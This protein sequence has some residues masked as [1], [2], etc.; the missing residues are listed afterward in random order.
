MNNNE[1]SDFNLENSVIVY[2]VYLEGFMNADAKLEDYSE[3]IDSG[4]TDFDEA[5]KCAD[6][7]F[8]NCDLPVKLK[9]ARITI[10][11]VLIHESGEREV[12]DCCYEKKFDKIPKA[13]IHL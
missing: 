4:Y 6:Y 5:K 3:V 2:E 11:S 13:E 12:L 10:Y 8:M 9:C 7:I 1:F